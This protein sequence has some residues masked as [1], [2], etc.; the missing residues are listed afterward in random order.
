MDKALVTI[1]CITFNHEKYI[2]DALEGFLMQRTDF[3][4]KVFIY[5]DASND[6]TD[7]ILQQYAKKFPEFFDIYISPKNTYDLQNRQDLLQKLCAKHI[8]G[9][10]V[11]L[12]DGDD[13]WIDPQKL[14][15]EVDFLES[16]PDV[17]MVAHA[18]EWLNCEDMTKKEYRLYEKDKYLTPEDVIVQRNGNL[19]TASLVMVRDA[20]IWGDEYPKC[21]VGDI[22]LQL[23]ALSKG[24]I[25]Y[26][27]RIMSVY[28][29]MC[30]GSWSK[31]FFE[32]L[33]NQL[34]HNMT[35][36]TFYIMYDK[37]TNYK[38]HYYLKQVVLN[39]LYANIFINAKKHK[40]QEIF[41]IYANINSKFRNVKDIVQEQKN[42]LRIIYA[43]KE[44]G[45]MR[46]Y[47]EFEHILIY[48][49][50]EFAKYLSIY[51]KKNDIEIDGYIISDNQNCRE[52]FNEKP[53]W[54]LRDYPYEFK[55]T[56]VCVAINQRQEVQI[57]AALKQYDIKNICA[58]FWFDLEKLWKQLNDTEI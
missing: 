8:E 54:H 42:M 5:D 28:R 27:N 17:T 45:E 51:Y 43:E 25:F 21:D 53:V 3:K 52:R 35:M 23:S 10:Y 56:L 15:V 58:P 41:L 50:G 31:S 6:G 33:S 20:F 13:Y 7:D 39:Y 55:D 49:Q 16:H 34:F 32:Q 22:P 4:V 36:V 40:I 26:F 12:C 18:S 37:Y 24:K 38:F 14:Q 2:K 44:N 9:K 11:A 47:H 48:G 46:K 30:E 57:R 29:Y 19:S 1:F